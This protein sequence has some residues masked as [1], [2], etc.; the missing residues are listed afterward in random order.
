MILFPVSERKA[1]ALQSKMDALGCHERDLEESFRGTSITI[2]HRPTGIRVRCN[3]E[4]SQA[5]NRFFARRLLV[6]ELEA[7]VQNKTRHEVKAEQLREKKGRN[8]KPRVD[9]SLSQFHL[10]PEKE[11]TVSP[12]IETLLKQW[13]AGNDPGRDTAGGDAASST[14]K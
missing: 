2:L 12:A 11:P 13:H 9:Q 10:R 1:K 4:R 3:R 5:L 14:Q 7:Q 8:K 6:E